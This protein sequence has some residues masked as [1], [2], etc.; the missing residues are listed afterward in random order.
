MN[1][2]IASETGV[3]G[4]FERALRS[5]RFVTTAEVTPPVST[6]RSDLLAKAMPL[7]GLAD[8]VNVTDGAGARAHLGSLT[9]SLILQENG[10]EPIV[11]FTCRDRNRIALQSDLL[12]AAALNIRN[13]LVLRGD[14]PKQGDQPDAKPVFDL[15]SKTLLE[16]AISIRDRGEL[17]HGRK[18]AGKA[19]YFMGAAEAPVDPAPDWRPKGLQVKIAA[20]AQFAQTQFCMDAG[21]VERYTRRL[22]DEGIPEDFYL[23]IGIAPLRSVK[24]ARWMKKNL[25]GTI[26]PDETIER[27]EQSNDALAEG[28]K[29]A[30]ELMQAFAEIPGVAG[31]HIMAPN[32]EEAIPEVLAAFGRRQR[33]QRGKASALAAADAEFSYLG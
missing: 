15:E 16:T 17:P 27:M 29:I 1:K 13:I 10:I 25:F 12:S 21:V 8:A 6:E 5:G 28:R 4:Q 24:S 2:P 30:V 18:V 14:D 7:R 26:I 9:S 3:S 19:H 23:L 11:Q 22:A 31:V 20:G 32:H 33:K